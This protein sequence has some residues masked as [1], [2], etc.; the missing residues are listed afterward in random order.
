MQLRLDKYFDRI[1]VINTNQR[2][3]RLRDMTERFKSLGLVKD[4]FEFIDKYRFEAI[5]GGH[6][7]RRNYNVT[8]DRGLNNG[9]LGCYLSHLEIYKQIVLNGWNKTLILE[10]DALF[11][12]E[13]FTD[14]GRHYEML[15]FDFDM[16]YLGRGNYDVQNLKKPQKELT[17]YGTKEEIAPGLFRSSRNWLTHAYVVN[18]KCARDLH[19]KASKEFYLTIDGVLA[20]IQDELNVFSSNPSLIIQDVKSRSSL[21]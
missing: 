7:D 1:L 6:V 2:A 13:F 10:D 12:P 9:E 20:D 21:R 15:P 18:G 3:D 14:F 4:Q 5:N 16:W 19:A 17:F 11:T 8:W